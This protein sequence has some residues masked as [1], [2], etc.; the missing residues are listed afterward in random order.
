M[1]K[2][3]LDRDFLLV[4]LCVPFSPRNMKNRV[5]KVIVLRDQVLLCNISYEFFHSCGYARPDPNCFTM[6]DEMDAPLKRRQSAKLI[7]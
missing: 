1:E 6:G 3:Q 5:H 7:K 4:N 2:F